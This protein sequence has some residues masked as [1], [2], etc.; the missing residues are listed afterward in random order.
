MKRLEWAQEDGFKDVVWTDETT[1]QLEA[2]RRFCSCKDGLK[3]RKPRPKHPVKVHVWAGI[4]WRGRTEICVFSGI[5]NVYLEILSQT[6][7]PFLLHVYPDGHRF[8]QEK[9]D[10]KHTSR[11]AQ[12]FFNAN[13][14]TT[15][16]ESPDANPIENLW[17]EL[18]VCNA[19]FSFHAYVVCVLYTHT[20]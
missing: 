17:H 11:K 12:T 8:M 18:N 10:P 1:V 4:S 5:M 2:H 16:L 6:L 7:V 19:Q 9:N 14:W 13:W 15:P 20:T 3:P